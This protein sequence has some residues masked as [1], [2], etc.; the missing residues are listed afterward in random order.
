MK[1][2]HFADYKEAK[3]RGDLRRKKKRKKKYVIRDIKSVSFSR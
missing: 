3:K 1:R 2:E